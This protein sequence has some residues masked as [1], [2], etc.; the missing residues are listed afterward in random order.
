M[1]NFFEAFPDLSVDD[2][3]YDYFSGAMVE[4]VS[5]SKTKML[6]FIYCRCDQLLHFRT[7]KNMERKL[8]K[9]VFEKLGFRPIL[10][11][12]Y[13][14][15]ER[16]ELAKLIS[17]YED[18]LKEEL[19]EQNVTDYMKFCAEPFQVQE[20]TITITCDDD[21]LCRQRSGEIE[22]FFQK[23]MKRRFDRDI[24]VCFTYVK[25]ERKKPAA[26][27]VY[28]MVIH[29]SDLDG[30]AAGDSS[31]GKTKAA[32]APVKKPFVPRRS[33]Y[34]KPSNDP[35]VFYGKNVEG[36]II[37]IKD[38]VDEIGEVVIDGMIRSVEQIEMKRDPDKLIVLITITDFTDTIVA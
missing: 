29:K 4:K 36:T 38:I 10:E 26:P 3:L 8:Y 2:K 14:F 17:M 27:E 11:L 6:A 30:G 25:R 9:Q 18:T 35:S 31:E 33:N 28:R 23:R 34:R 7:V 22:A 1:V 21:F 37:P 13:P 5:A 16:M 15:A 24:Q 32:P 20:N 19:R 12:T